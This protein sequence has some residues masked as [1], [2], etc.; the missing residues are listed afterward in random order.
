M[1]NSRRTKIGFSF[2]FAALQRTIIFVLFKL[3]AVLTAACSALLCS[4][5]AL[6]FANHP[7]STLFT[8]KGCIK[9]TKP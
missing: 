7:G 8:A 4:A 2:M 5:H 9:T 1:T 3:A 6:L